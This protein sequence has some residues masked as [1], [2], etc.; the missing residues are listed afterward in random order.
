MK[1]PFFALRAAA[2]PSKMMPVCHGLVF[3]GTTGT[4]SA[5]RRTIAFNRAYRA[6]PALMGFDVAIEPGTAA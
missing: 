3:V 6:A 4:N 5:R 2:L 1:T